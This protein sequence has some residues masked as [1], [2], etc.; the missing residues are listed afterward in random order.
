MFLA[1][2]LL[3]LQSAQSHAAAT[4]M[5][6]PAV[7]SDFLHL[8]L[9]ALWFGGLLSML[10]ALL[11]IPAGTGMRTEVVAP[12]STHEPSPATDL[13]PSWYKRSTG[14]TRQTIDI[15]SNKLATDCTPPRARKEATNAS[16]NAF[17][18]DRFSGR[19]LVTH[20]HSRS[21]TLVPMVA[22]RPMLSTWSFPPSMALARSIH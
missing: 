10:V 16:A 18:S 17:S 11:S 19:F 15:V 14:N 13:F 6:L 20:N 5:P 4:G 22:I 1:G 12:F 7:I 9:A 21:L 3:L 8:T 2:I